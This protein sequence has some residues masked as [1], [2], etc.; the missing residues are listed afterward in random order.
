M[1]GIQ[2]SD[3]YLEY[4]G[5]NFRHYF[6]HQWTSLKRMRN[7]EYPEKTF[8]VTSLLQYLKTFVLFYLGC[9]VLRTR[10]SCVLWSIGAY[11]WPYREQIM[12]Y[13]F[14]MRFFLGRFFDTLYWS[15]FLI[16][17]FLRLGTHVR[18]QLIFNIH[19]IFNNNYF[20][21]VNFIS[22]YR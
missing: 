2:P 7:R 22:S 8:C 13:G 21:R 5:K 11:W 6:A 16:S 15:T 17:I 10:D 20:L 14:C 18:I 4:A 19:Y 3:S 1:Q 12:S 9:I